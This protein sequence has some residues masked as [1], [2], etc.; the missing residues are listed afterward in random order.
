MTQILNRR[1]NYLPTPQQNL[2]T[3][4]QTSKCAL[5]LSYDSFLQ[6]PI[7]PAHQKLSLNGDSRR[8]RN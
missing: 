5:P 3:S 1:N 4:L 6:Q 8:R 2:E 7:A